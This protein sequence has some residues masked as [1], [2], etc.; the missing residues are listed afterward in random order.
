MSYQSMNIYSNNPRFQENQRNAQDLGDPSTGQR[1]N[2]TNDH[3]GQYIM[4]NSNGV[5]TSTQQAAAM[6]MRGP[7]PNK[8]GPM[9]GGTHNPIHNNPSK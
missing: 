4:N 6:I 8:M 3:A 2:F 1:N 9:L 5:P 7:D